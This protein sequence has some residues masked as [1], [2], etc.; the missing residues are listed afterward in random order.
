MSRYVSPNEAKQRQL[1]RLA[2]IKAEKEAAERQQRRE[3]MQAALRQN[4]VTRR[5]MSATS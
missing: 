2:Q 4:Q 1:A 3:R 5:E